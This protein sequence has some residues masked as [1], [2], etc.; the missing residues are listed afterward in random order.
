MTPGKDTIGPVTASK[1]PRRPPRGGESSGP[2]GLSHLDATGAVRMVDVGAKE[3]TRREAHASARVRMLP[4]TLETIRSGT[5]AKGDV[6][7]TARIAGIQGAK[8]TSRLIPLCHPLP[9]ERVAVEFAFEGD[10]LVIA[11]EAAAT[12][13]TGVEMEA[14][15]AAAVAALTVYDMLKAIDRGMTIGKI[16]LM[17]KSGGRSGTW[18]RG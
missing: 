5:A 12:A 10:A 1:E 4:A 15:T 7:A 6:L 2:G 16:R 8:E 9:L 11:T 18:R 14:L 3:V 17:K 13:R